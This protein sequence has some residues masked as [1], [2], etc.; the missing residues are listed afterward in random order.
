[1]EIFNVSAILTKQHRQTGGEYAK[2]CLKFRDGSFSP[3]DHVTL[4][5]RNYDVL[6]LEEKLGF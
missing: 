4:Q 5:K 1:M 2:L 3:E 6:P